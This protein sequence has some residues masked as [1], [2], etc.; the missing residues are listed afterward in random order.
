MML[1]PLRSGAV[2]STTSSSTGTVSSSRSFAT[3]VAGTPTNG[4]GYGNSIA[5]MSQDMTQLLNVQIAMMRENLMFTAI[6]NILKTKHDTVKTIV[7]NIR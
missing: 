4:L 5:E 6:S 3:L 7:S 1:T 2:A